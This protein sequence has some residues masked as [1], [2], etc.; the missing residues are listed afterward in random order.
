MTRSVRCALLL[1]MFIAPAAFAAS[2]DVTTVQ[3]EVIDPSSYLREGR[4]GPDA[5][6]SMY[7][8]VDGGQS[9]A[10]LDDKGQTVYL[11]LASI[12]GEDP[13]QLVYEYAGQ[14][15]KV[16]GTVYERAGLTGLVATSVEP[17]TPTGQAP[18]KTGTTPVEP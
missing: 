11:F 1:G 12:P 15:V 4:H 9:L 8:A 13:N 14:K 2:Q 17:L 18:A 6:E 10:L 7:D 5:E 3:G 16:T